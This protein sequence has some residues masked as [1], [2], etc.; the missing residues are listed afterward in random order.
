METKKTVRAMEMKAMKGS[1]E[2]STAN[3]DMQMYPVCE[4]EIETEFVGE[5]LIE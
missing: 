2:P 1:F 3:L 5:W 4:R